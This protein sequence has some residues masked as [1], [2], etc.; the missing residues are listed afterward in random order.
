[1]CLAAVCV[2][3]VMFSHVG[4]RH[5]WLLSCKNTGI[6]SVS[7]CIRTFGS[8]ICLYFFQ[9]NKLIRF[10]IMYFNELH[11]TSFLMLMYEIPV[12]WQ[13]FVVRVS[14]ESQDK[15]TPH[16]SVFSATGTSH[17]NS[18]HQKIQLQAV[19]PCVKPLDCVLG[20]WRHRN[21]DVTIDYCTTTTSTGWHSLPPFPLPPQLVSLPS[22]LSPPLFLPSHHLVPHAV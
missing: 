6:T 15:L 22:P 13:F 2:V 7:I 1:M 4:L 10:L 12:H 19:I 16:Q 11:E 20:R 14:K 17:L 18:T 8:G 9:S 21:R 3:R 5:T